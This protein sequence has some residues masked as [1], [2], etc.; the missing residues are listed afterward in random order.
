MIESCDLSY[1]SPSHDTS[2][3]VD[4]V[5]TELYATMKPFLTLMA[6][7]LFGSFRS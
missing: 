7:I 3:S 6:Q 5:Q 4:L 1:L 2:H